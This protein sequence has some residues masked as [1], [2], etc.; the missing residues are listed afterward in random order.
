M[1][2]KSSLLDHSLN[3]IS[4]TYPPGWQALE[5]SN[6]QT[7]RGV[8]LFCKKHKSLQ[9]LFAKS[10]S[11]EIH[12]D[13]VWFSSYFIMYYLEANPPHPKAESWKWAAA[14]VC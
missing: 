13:K 4:L 2:L 1:Q 7:V 3:K 8:K 11:P 10:D 9:K 14:G 12:G 6:I 5:H